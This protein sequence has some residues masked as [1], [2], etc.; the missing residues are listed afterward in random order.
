M[1]QGV[2]GRGV[3]AGCWVVRV[4]FVVCWCVGFGGLL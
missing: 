1:G 2:W 4:V 3:C